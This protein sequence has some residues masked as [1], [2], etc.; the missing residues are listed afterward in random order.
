M[1]KIILY[2]VGLAGEKFYWAYKNKYQIDYVLDQCNN[3]FFHNIPVYSFE[4]KTRLIRMFCDQCY[5]KRI[6]YIMKYPKI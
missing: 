4:E 3:I 1:K 2:G 6:Q 5:R